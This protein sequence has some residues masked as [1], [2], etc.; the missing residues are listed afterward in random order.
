[1][2]KDEHSELRSQQLDLSNNFVSG[3][4]EITTSSSIEAWNVFF[5]IDIHCH[6]STNFSPNKGPS[7]SSS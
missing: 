5:I 7:R 4:Y 1:M 2:I 3:I 6:D